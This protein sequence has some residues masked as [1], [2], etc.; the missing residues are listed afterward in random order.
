LIK[1]LKAA[2][3]PWSVN[4]LAQLAGFECLRNQAYIKKSVALVEW[5]RKYLYHGL[6]NAYSDRIVHLFR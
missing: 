3:D 1:E 2:K 4:S 6:K 5:E